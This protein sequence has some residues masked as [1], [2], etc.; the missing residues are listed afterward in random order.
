VFLFTWH[1]QLTVLNCVYCYLYPPGV[2]CVVLCIHCVTS[3]AHCMKPWFA[4]RHC[5]GGIAWHTELA[6]AYLLSVLRIQPGQDDV[7]CMLPHCLPGMQ[8][9]CVLVL[10]DPAVPASSC[11]WVAGRDVRWSQVG[12]LPG[13]LCPCSRKITECNHRHQAQTS[14]ADIKH[15]HQAQTSSTDIRSQA[16]GRNDACACRR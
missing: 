10:E 12:G 16:G 4:W 13:N 2:V 6:V 11:A 1:A 3:K 8:V 7:V 15:R 5:I 9:G 14:S